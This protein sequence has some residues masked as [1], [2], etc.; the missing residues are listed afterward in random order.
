MNL[1]KF[2]RRFGRYAQDGL[3]STATDGSLETSAAAGQGSTGAEDE[4][5]VDEE[6]QL[7]P[8]GSLT[9]GLEDEAATAAL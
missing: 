6:I 4:A 3:D 5:L 8:T 2:F 9:E 1:R 7:P